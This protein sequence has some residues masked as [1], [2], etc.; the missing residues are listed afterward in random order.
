MFIS[1]T[2]MSEYSKRN[3]N[4]DWAARNS[5]CWLFMRRAEPC[6]PPWNW[7]KLKKNKRTIQYSGLL[8]ILF[9]IYITL[10]FEKITEID[11]NQM[12]CVYLYRYRDLFIQYL[13]YSITF[14]LIVSLKSRFLLGFKIHLKFVTISYDNIS[15][16]FNIFIIELYK[17]RFYLSLCEFYWKIQFFLAPL[18]IVLFDEFESLNSSSR[19]QLHFRLDASHDPRGRS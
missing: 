11:L 16:P 12:Y 9:H 13:L 2:L 15:L 7:P 17:L 18:Y 14:L 4:T 8:F 10:L 1:A 19:L 3:W 5:S 6:K